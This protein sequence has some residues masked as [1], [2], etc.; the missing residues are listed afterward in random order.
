[1]VGSD[2]LRLRLRIKLNVFSLLKLIAL[3]TNKPDA[4]SLAFYRSLTWRL[5]FMILVL[6]LFFY[7][8]SSTNPFKSQDRLLSQT[9][10]P[11]DA[12]VFTAQT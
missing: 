9:H 4:F 11:R 6:F 5:E 3:L 12:L 1:M 10:K 7:L 2:D 8:S